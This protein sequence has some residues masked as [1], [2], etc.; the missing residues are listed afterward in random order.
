M[1]VR[2]EVELE[3][4]LAVLRRQVETLTE[5][6]LS[7]RVTGAAV[8][9]LMARYHVDR[10]AAFS[11]LRRLSQESNTKLVEVARAIVE[12]A[13]EHHRRGGTGA[14]RTQLVNRGEQ[15]LAR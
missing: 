12:D 4:E 3:Q 14:C 8:G 15:S 13:E 11:L 10:A 5:G 6:L 7:N 9:L 1:G 2:I